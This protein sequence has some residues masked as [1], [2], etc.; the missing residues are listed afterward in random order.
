M[1]ATRRQ[2]WQPQLRPLQRKFIFF[3]NTFPDQQIPM[4]VFRTP[5]YFCDY[6][7]DITYYDCK[8]SDGLQQQF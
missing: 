1:A 2:R 3:G 5:T 8:P 6:E 4:A 7:K